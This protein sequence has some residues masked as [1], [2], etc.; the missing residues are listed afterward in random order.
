MQWLPD[1]TFVEIFKTP[2]DFG[3][4]N[5][6]TYIGTVAVAYIPVAFV[7]FAEHIADHKNL[8]T[9]IDKD[10]L[11]DPGLSRTLLGDGIGSFVG[12]IFGGCLTQHMVKVSDVLQLQEMPQ[13]LQSLQLQFSQLHFRL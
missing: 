13:S 2:L 3:S 9:I 7:V 4:T 5:I 10:L 6:A 8:S 1:F 12:A 11:D